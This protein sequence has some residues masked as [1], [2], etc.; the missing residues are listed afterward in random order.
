MERENT[1]IVKRLRDA[2]RRQR[3]ATEHF[4]RVIREASASGMS[5]RRIAPFVGLSFQRVAQI[6]RGER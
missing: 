4:R 6:A 3:E 5:Y 2:A 1:A